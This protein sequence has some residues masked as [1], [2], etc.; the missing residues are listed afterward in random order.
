MGLGDEDYRS[1]EPFSIHQIK[2]ICR[3]HDFSP[4]ANLITWL[5]QRFPDFFTVQLLFLSSHSI[6]LSLK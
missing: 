4:I 6:L 2:G 5:R 3:Q 1:E